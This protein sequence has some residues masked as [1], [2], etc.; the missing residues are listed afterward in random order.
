[1]V[2]EPFLIFG[3][4]DFTRYNSVYQGDSPHCL[5]GV[6]HIWSIKIIH[7]QIAIL[8]KIKN[9]AKSKRLK[10]V[11]GRAILFFAWVTNSQSG[12]SCEGSALFIQTLHMLPILDKIRKPFGSYLTPITTG[13]QIMLTIQLLNHS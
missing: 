4:L 7:G 12:H 13:G 5:L 2:V 3:N 11:T 10:E 8:Y 9:F 6:F 1:V